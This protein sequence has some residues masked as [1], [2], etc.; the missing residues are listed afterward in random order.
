[1]MKPNGCVMLMLIEQQQ[2][3]VRRISNQ[4]R[5]LREAGMLESGYLRLWCWLCKGRK[6]QVPH[7]AKTFEWVAGQ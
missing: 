1:M 3:T 2:A 4:E 6:Q 7:Q 5:M